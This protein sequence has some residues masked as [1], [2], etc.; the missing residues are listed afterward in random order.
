M[1]HGL[2]P[3]TVKGVIWFQGDGN[4]QH[5]EEYPE[6]IQTVIKT[7]RAHWGAE[8]P[9]YYLEINNMFALQKDPVERGALAPIREAQ[10]AAL[11]LPHTGVVSTIDLGIAEDA[12]FPV[13]QPAGDRMAKLVLSE[14]YG[15]S[16]G[17]VHSPQFSGMS[18]EGNKVWLRFDHAEGLRTRSGSLT[19]FALR[20]PDG[21]WTWADGKI[22]RGEIVLWND[23][24]A[25]PA[26]VRYGWANNP[27][28]SVENAVGLPLRPFRTDK[29]SPY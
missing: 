7:W 4:G 27:I 2:E 23:Q 6:L 5:P 8:L 1:I 18:I 9:F 20:G 3:Y 24:I 22:D 25:H 17:E 21:T 28:I 29:N 13:K 16:E 11:E 10:N 12:H 26:A 14:V 15:I 19:G